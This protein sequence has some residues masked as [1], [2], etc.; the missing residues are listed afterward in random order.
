MK[1]SGTKVMLR[2]IGLVKPLTGWMILAILMGLAGHLCASGI[3]VLGGYAVLELLQVRVGIGLAAVFAGVSIFAVLRGLLRYGEQSCNHYIAFKLL[4][5]LRDQVFSALRRLCPAKLEGRDRGDLIAVI[6]SDIELLEVFYAHTISPIAI[7]ILFSLISSL[8]ISSFH[9]LLGG[10]AVAAYLTV[11]LLIPLLISKM[12]GAD[13]MYF[14]TKSGEL[15]SF[16]LDSLRGLDQ[17]IQYGAGESRQEQMKE[18]SNAL[19]LDEA[20][21]KRVAGR[22]LAMTNTI[23][24]LFDLVMLCSCALLYQSGEIGFAGVLLPT[25]ALMSSFGPVVALANLGST[26]QNTFAAGNRVLDIL[27]ET[28]V[29]EEIVGREPVQFSKAADNRCCRTYR[30]RFQKT[31]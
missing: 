10:I 16:V 3:T 13:G 27:E 31:V 28:P 11:G 14:R 30:W 1:R 26:L 15:S 18:K 24:L 22:N 8:Y 29:V 20:R 19:S 23:I 5:L 25:L 21:M 6:T 17:T 4:A 9:P 2:L 7:A 12:S